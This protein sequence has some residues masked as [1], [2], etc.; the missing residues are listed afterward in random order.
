MTLFTEISV[1][2]SYW[3]MGPTG[4]INKQRNELSSRYLQSQ[5]ETA[6]ER[7][8]ILYDSQSLLIRKRRTN[9]SGGA[10]Q[11]RLRCAAIVL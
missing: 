3:A 10:L 8:R 9:P 4:T 11:M 2:L 7:E 1:T 5:G 6:Q